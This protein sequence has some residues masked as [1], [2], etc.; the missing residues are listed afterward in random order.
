MSENIQATTS[1]KILTP[2]AVKSTV[3]LLNQHIV[4]LDRISTDIRSNTMAIIDRG[5]IIRAL[6]SALKESDV[7]LTQIKSEEEARE[8]ILA[9]LKS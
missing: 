3:T 9:K 4:W 7:D 1:R 5:A 2:D 8:I 6:I